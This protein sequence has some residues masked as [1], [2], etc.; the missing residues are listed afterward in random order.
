[1]TEIRVYTSDFCPYCVNAKRLL[2]ARGLGYSE[3]NIGSDF[4]K[5]KWLIE[6]TGQRTV[7]QIFI[8]DKSIG[9]Y[10]EL[11]ALDRSGELVKLAQ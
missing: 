10:T 4:E 2:D 9:G 11:V 7:P 8:G 6:T 3:V 1:M 5:R